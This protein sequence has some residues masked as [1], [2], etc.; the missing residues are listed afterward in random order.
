MYLFKKIL[1]IILFAGI[2]VLAQNS[3]LDSLITEAV[4]VSPKLKMLNAKY[5]AAESKS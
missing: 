4:K 1:I 3:G 5:S 2:P